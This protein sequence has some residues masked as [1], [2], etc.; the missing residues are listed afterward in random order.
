MIQILK[1]SVD[2]ITPEKGSVFS[3]STLFFVLSVQSNVWCDLRG[4]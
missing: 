2:P 3:V 1:N 4:T